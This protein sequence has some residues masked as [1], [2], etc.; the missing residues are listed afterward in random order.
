MR[1]SWFY[2]VNKIFSWI[3]EIFIFHFNFMK[4]WIMKVEEHGTGEAVGKA[5][6]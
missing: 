2:L 3:F 4:F 6:V 5:L 1:I